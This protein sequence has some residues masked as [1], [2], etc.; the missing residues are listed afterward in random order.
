VASYARGAVAYELEVWRVLGDRRALA[1][2]AKQLLWRLRCVL[3]A[4]PRRRDDPLG[5]RME[6][7]KLRHELLGVV[8]WRR[9]R[10]AAAQRRPRALLRMA[11]P[12][13]V[14]PDREP[15]PVLAVSSGP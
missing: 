7:L 12:A 14:G 10:R 8:A 11:P 9:S 4:V 5:W 3:G 13:A 1:G 2:L 15:E 6:R